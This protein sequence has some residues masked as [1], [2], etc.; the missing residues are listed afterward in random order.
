MGKMQ[1]VTELQLETT[2]TDYKPLILN[3]VETVT[4][5]TDCTTT[6]NRHSFAR[7]LAQMSLKSAL[8]Q[9]KCQ[10]NMVKRKSSYPY[11]GS[12]QRRTG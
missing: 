8:T 6:W 1:Q 3:N 10:C 4:F 2:F 12:M 5:S 11:Y 7:F 9:E